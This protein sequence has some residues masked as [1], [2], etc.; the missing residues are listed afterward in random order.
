MIK[1]AHKEDSTIVATLAKELWNHHSLEQLKEEFENC[2]QSKNNVVYLYFESDKPIAFAYCS[3]RH[4]YVEGATTTPVAYLEGIY[5]KKNYRLTGIS[6]V[7]IAECEKWAIKNHCQ[8]IASDC[9]L[10]NHASFQF[11]VKNGF[12][13]TNRIICFTKTLSN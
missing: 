7:L 3:L 12:I 1:Q 2:L 11:H 8:E 5:V 4:D 9:E 6:K 10:E 13:E